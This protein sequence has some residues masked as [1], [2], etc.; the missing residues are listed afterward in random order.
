MSDGPTIL[1]LESDD[2]VTSVVR[3]IRA[4]DPGHVMVVA[5]GRSR[6]TSSVVALRLLARA[7]DADSRPLTIVGDALTRSLAAE[8]GVPAFGTLDEARRSDG[9][10][11][12]PPDPHRAA[13]HVVRGPATDDTAPTLAAASVAAAAVAAPKEVAPIPGDADITRSVPVVR[14]AP[15][16]APRAST[17]RRRALPAALLGAV[18]LLLA[19]AIVVA[20]AFLPAATITIAPHAETVGPRPYAVVVDDVSRHEGTATATAEVVASGTYRVQEPASG[21]V[22]LFNWTFFPVEVPAG[23]FVA[24]GEQAFATQAAVVVPRGRLTG[25]GTIAAGDVEV[26][27]VAAAP[28]PAANVAAEAINV[29]VNEDVDARLRGFPENPQPRVLN[30]APTEGGTDTSGPEI[31]QADVDAAVEALRGELA[32][33]VEAAVADVPEG[34]TVVGE[35]VE[36]TIEG[37]EGLVG[38]RDQ[39]TAEIQG[40]RPWSVDVADPDQVTAAAE[41]A[42]LDDPAAVPD[43]T[44]ILE[45]ST[46]VTVGEATSEGE[47]MQVDT[48]VSARAAPVIDP[49]A[50]RETVAGATVEEAE[51]ALTD[52]GQAS[53][54]LWPGWVT[55]VPTMDARVEVVIVD[56]EAQAP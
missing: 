20:A 31:I 5:P 21:S 9:S 4:A 48:T 27:V 41:S 50:V 44:E 17:A 22:S 26:A 3:R 40:S 56:A 28:G 23:T 16:P 51:A 39:E 34:V 49:E 11:P 24:A 25:A 53:V 36:A 29:V 15:A 8:A 52:V 38:T 7:A 55:T 13:I 43:G 18:A 47:S 54:E 33:S 1:Y 10:A 37:V 42:F 19:G 12:P 45:G 35:P 32:Q 2:E 30:P 14:P 6:A 46:T